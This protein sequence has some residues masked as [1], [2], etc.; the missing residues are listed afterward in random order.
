MAELNLTIGEVYRC[1][2]YKIY[3]LTLVDSW[4]YIGHVGTLSTY[5]CEW[6]GVHRANAQN[7]F[8]MLSVQKIST[9]FVWQG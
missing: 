7:K 6:I 5:T 3:G 4:Q 1:A 9:V 8:V 2:L